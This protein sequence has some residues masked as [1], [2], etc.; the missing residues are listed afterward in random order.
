MVTALILS[1]GIGARMFSDIPKQYIEVCGKPILMYTMERLEQHAG[2]DAIVVAAAAKWQLRIS[3]WIARAGL[4]KFSGFAEAGPSR[5]ESLFNGLKAMKRG[6]A[7]R[8]L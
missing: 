8:M 4:H 2:V 7:L 6:G 5:Q 1:G 3:D